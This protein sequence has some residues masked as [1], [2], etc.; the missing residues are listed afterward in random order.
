[1]IQTLFYTYVYEQVSG[2]KGVEPN[3]YVARKLRGESSL[4]YRSGRGRMVMQGAFLESLKTGFVDFLRH[5]LEELFDASV[6]FTD[7]SGAKVY[8]SD[9]YREFIGQLHP[10][11][12]DL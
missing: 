10:E 12:E 7:N 8:P 5:T 2:R 4:F 9:P 11:S 6:P 1:M 3:L